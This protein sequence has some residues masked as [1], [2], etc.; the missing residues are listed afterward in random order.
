MY[1]DESDGERAELAKKQMAIAKWKEQSKRLRPK[2]HHVYVLSLEEVNHK[3][4]DIEPI[5]LGVFD[6]K[7]AAVAKSITVETN[8]GTF[9]EAVKDMFSDSYDYIDN[10]S[11]PPD[12]GIL[13]QL[14]GEDDYGDLIRVMI[15]KH[16]VMSLEDPEVLAN[17]KKRALKSDPES[18][19]SK[20]PLQQKKQRTREDSS[21][22]DSYSDY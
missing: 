4:R 11:D 19:G 15:H 6:S 14:G 3:L 21:D 2:Q 12:N 17:E 5:S 16:S 8:Y 20:N 1:S 22:Q 9:D 7:E 13:F 18:G 10:R